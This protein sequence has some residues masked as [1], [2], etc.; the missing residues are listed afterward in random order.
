MFNSLICKVFGSSKV[1]AKIQKLKDL[2]KNFN[3]SQKK[4]MSLVDQMV[5]EQALINSLFNAVP[6]WLWH[7]DAD[8]VYVRANKKIR[9]EL[10]C[11]MTEDEVVGK[12]DVQIAQILRD[13]FGKENHTFGELCA[14]SDDI[15]TQIQVPIRFNEW[16]KVKGKLLRVVVH[17]NVIRDTCGKVVGTVGAGYNITDDYNHLQEI[18]ILTTDKSTARLLKAFRDK[19][20]FELESS[21][22][23]TCACDNDNKSCNKKGVCNG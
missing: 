10:F 19:D 14:G 8:G 6:D 3:E 13:K 12:N 9:N 18:E 5:A 2:E 16:G 23:I 15:V 17:K 1:R 20:V 11:G 4:I 21:K 22:Q 7:K